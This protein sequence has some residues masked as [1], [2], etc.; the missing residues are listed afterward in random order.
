M[1][2]GTSVTPVGTVNF[3]RLHEKEIEYEF[4]DM[5]LCPLVEEAS[6]TYR[7]S[8]EEEGLQLLIRCDAGSCAHADPAKVACSSPTPASISR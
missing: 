1:L 8:L 3:V 4:A 2:A 7:L 6:E 5:G